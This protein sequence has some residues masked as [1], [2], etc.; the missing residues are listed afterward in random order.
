MIKQE[1]F[2]KII[3]VLE[4]AG[5]ETAPQVYS[6]CFDIL[7][8]GK[9]ILLIKILTNIDSFYEQ[10]ADDLKRIASVLEASP[11][12]IGLIARGQYMKDKTIYERYGVPA[13]N[14][15]T[16]KDII[17]EKKLPFVYAKKGGF[18][19]YVNPEFLRRIRNSHKLSLGELARESGISK[20]ALI[21]YEQGKGA[22]IEN[23][24]RLKNA[25]GDVLLNTI[26]PFDFVK[27]G[28]NPSSLPEKDS[29]KEHLDE[30]GFETTSVKKASFKVIGKHKD[31]IVLTGVK[32]RAL[33]KEAFDIS[34]LKDVLGQH[35]MIVLEKTK[36]TIVAGVPVLSRDELKE[37][38]SSKELLKI[39]KEIEG[40][41]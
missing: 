40:S 38:V 41:V 30:I 11:L 5:Y 23:I 7:A 1:L 17:L 10:Q 3:A 21:N 35:G 6:S 33:Q 8:K 20:T 15:E 22:E 13:I 29:V 14:L 12:I 28:P 27:Q 24:I 36:E 31:D 39:L 32:A 34:C 26:N 18:Y 9:K 37:V 2:Q 4:E 25:I 19:A 16:F